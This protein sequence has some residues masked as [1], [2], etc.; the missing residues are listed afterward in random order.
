ML[1]QARG[2]GAG[3]AGAIRLKTAEANAMSLVGCC[4]FFFQATYGWRGERGDGAVLPKLTGIRA[5]QV[6]EP[7]K[8][9]IHASSV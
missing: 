3:H 1:D 4:L 9:G 5:E 2:A 7:T 8:H 6:L